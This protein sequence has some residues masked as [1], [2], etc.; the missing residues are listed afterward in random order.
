MN[1]VMLVLCAIGICCA[2]N[3]IAME[4][5]GS[6]KARQA[7]NERIA[8]LTL[9]FNGAISD[10]ALSDDIL[11]FG[12]HHNTAGFQFAFSVAT[13]PSSSYEEA[14]EMLDSIYTVLA[15]EFKRS[16]NAPPDAEEFYA[17]AIAFMDKVAKLKKVA[18]I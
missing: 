2:N 4:L 7:L 3:A 11:K 5:Q 14:R 18:K 16:G 12:Q 10:E 8:D 6:E 15:Q 1:R 17:L 13:K 9:L